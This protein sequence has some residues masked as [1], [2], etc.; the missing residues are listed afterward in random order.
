MIFDKLDVE[1][2]KTASMVCRRWAELAFSGR[3]M[4]RVLLNVVDYIQAPFSMNSTF[5]E[6][7]RNYRHIRYSYNHEDA[8]LNDLLYLVS[9][10]KSSLQTLIIRPDRMFRVYELQQILLKLPDLQH[11]I[12][13]SG[14]RYVLEKQKSFCV[15]HKL[16]SLRFGKMFDLPWD[17]FDIRTVTPNLD[18]LQM[19]CGSQQALEVWKHFS[20]QLTSLGVYVATYDLFLSFCA[21]AFPLLKALDYVV[22]HRQMFDSTANDTNCRFLRNLT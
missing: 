17:G 2:L 19:D 8:S 7:N 12:V 18:C 5:L 20:G 16:R 11:M 1:G 13:A 21:L 3:R 9:L 15:K 14:L 22:S 6:S 4:D 10:F